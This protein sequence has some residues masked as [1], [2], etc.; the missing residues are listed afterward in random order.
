[1]IPGL[2]G[3]E[4][5]AFP[6]STLPATAGVV[7]DEQ[8]MIPGEAAGTEQRLTHDWTVLTAGGRMSMTDMADTEGV[9]I[10]SSTGSESEFPNTKLGAAP[11]TGVVERLCD[12]S[13]GG[14]RSR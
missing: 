4:T 3:T 11:L 6:F 8:V 12:S 9:L 1:M 7:D 2:A 13:C 14:L 5:E 10:P